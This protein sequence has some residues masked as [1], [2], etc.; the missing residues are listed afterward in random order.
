MRNTTGNPY[1]FVDNTDDDG[2][3]E[4]D[5]QPSGG[6]GTSAAA[7]G[8]N[9]VQVTKYIEINEVVGLSGDVDTGTKAHHYD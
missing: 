8:D 9:T 7:S 3:M 2:M 1:P 4:L 5:M 6:S